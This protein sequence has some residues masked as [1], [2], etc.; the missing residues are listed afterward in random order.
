MI[1]IRS[2]KDPGTVNASANGRG[3]AFSRVKPPRA[4]C[5]HGSWTPGKTHE[6]WSPVAAP[7]RVCRLGQAG[8]QNWIPAWAAATG[9]PS[10]PRAQECASTGAASTS[11]SGEVDQGAEAMR[12]C[13]TEVGTKWLRKRIRPRAARLGKDFVRVEVRDLGFRWGSARPSDGPP[14]MNIHWATLQLPPSLIDYVLVHELA[15]LR[16]REPHPRVLVHRRTPH[17]RLPGLQDH[18][19]RCRQEHLARSNR[20]RGRKTNCKRQIENCRR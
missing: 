18:P 17:A 8:G 16:E 12:R 13:Y 6:Q 9:S 20:E 19:G 2:L 10:S 3:Y 1:Y 5:P 4:S 14:R 15:H 11:R 7:P